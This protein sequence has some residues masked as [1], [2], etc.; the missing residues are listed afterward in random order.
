MKG[1]VFMDRDGTISEEVGYLNELDQLRLIPKSVEAIK[2][3]NESGL[4]AI[5][6][7]NQSGVARGYFTEEMVHRVHE[8]M[9][10]LLDERDVHLDGIYHCPH[11]PEGVVESYRKTCNCRKPASGL[12]KKA[13]KDHG[14]DLAASYIVGD[15]LIDIELAYK[16]GAKG[17][18]VLTGYG[19]DELE[20][21]N[22]V[23]EIRPAYVADTLFDAAKWIIND[24]GV[25]SDGNPDCKIECHR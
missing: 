15:K 12:L 3:I 6:I 13:S 20:K 7:T 21:I 9:E 14:I 2:L 22:D 8:K 11:H 1:A 5:V 16:V 18:L 4:M 25:K 23:P 24:L 17:I 19:K 10:K